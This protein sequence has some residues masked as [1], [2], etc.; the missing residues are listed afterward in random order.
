MSENI[1]ITVKVNG[2]NVPLSTI[3]TETFEKIKKAEAQKDEFP[4]A[5][6]ADF[7][8]GIRAE[9]R[10]IIRVPENIKH[11]LHED[12]IVLGVDRGAAFVKNSGDAKYIK[13]SY[14][15]IEEIR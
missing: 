14:K 12:Y 8:T 13:R 15:N 4:I 7:E 9:R 10:L 11:H 1:E 5:A 3:S 2:Q 6:T